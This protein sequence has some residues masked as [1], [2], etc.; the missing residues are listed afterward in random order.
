MYHVLIVDDEYWVGRWLK[1]LLEKS[2]FELG[3]IEVCQEVEAALFILK[4]KPVDILITDINMPVLTGLEL[5]KYTKESGRKVPKA[6]VIS[7]YDEFEY[8]RQAIELEVLAYLIKPLE[9][10][11]VYGAVKKAIDSLELEHRQIENAQTG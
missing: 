11:A 3:M 7:G 6:I 4:Q 1:E 10:E 9:R 5:I 2:P 8:A